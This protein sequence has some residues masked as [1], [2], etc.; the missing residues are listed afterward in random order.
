MG[1]VPT[2]GLVTLLD[3]AP[4][5]AQ[6]RS[7]QERD[8]RE[9]RVKANKNADPSAADDAGTRRGPLDHD[10][11]REQP[12]PGP[13][14]LWSVRRERLVRSPKR[15]PLLRRGR[16]GPRDDGDRHAPVGTP[17][18]LLRPHAELP[19]GRPAP[20]SHALRPGEGSPASRHQ[21]VVLHF[22]G[23]WDHGGTRRLPLLGARGSL[24]PQ[25]RVIRTDVHRLRQPADA[26]RARDRH[27]GRAKR[28]GIF[29]G[30]RCPPRS[31]RQGRRRSWTSTTG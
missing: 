5:V 6:A 29:S 26:G 12:R 9:W 11:P 2:L 27:R 8:T 3:A 18:A 16:G 20:P 10:E 31:S 28:R 4:V 14:P 19:G 23:R 1:L 30:R 17:L 22:H 13:G 25:G 21:P 24:R 7:S 15:L